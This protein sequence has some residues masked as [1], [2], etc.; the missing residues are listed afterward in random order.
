MALV[1][2]REGILRD[3]GLHDGLLVGI[4]LRPDKEEL[5]LDCRSVDGKDIRLTLPKL[6]RLRVDNFLQG[7]II[8]DI[9]IHEGDRCSPQ[10][11]KRVYGYDDDD[12]QKWISTNMKEI[13]DGR[14]T[15]VEVSTS[16]GC[17]LVALCGAHADQITA[18]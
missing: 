11:V 8:C 15:L 4:N 1:V 16:Y 10:A 9:S 7:N 14:W 6:I 12:A 17:E 5:L 3:P 18:E 2:D 13:I